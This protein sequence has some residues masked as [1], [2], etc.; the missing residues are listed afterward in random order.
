MDDKEAIK[1]AAQAE[2]F[3]MLVER[4][5][6]FIGTDYR[7]LVRVGVPEG[8]AAALTQGFQAQLYFSI[9]APDHAQPAD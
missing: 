7:A 2:R 8:A 1:Q 9:F 5:G 6:E 4:F 3:E